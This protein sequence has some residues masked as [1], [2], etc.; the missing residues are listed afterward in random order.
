[1]TFDRKAFGDVCGHSQAADRNVLTP[2]TG[3]QD[4]MSPDD[5]LLA[6][7]H[8]HPAACRVNAF[9]RAVFQSLDA[10][11]FTDGSQGSKQVARSHASL[12]GIIEGADQAFQV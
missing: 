12:V 1:M 5:L 9:N 10:F 3:S 4:E 2:G 6:D 11:A 8:H 7:S